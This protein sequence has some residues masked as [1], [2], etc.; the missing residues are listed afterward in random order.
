MTLLAVTYPDVERL[1]VTHLA[2][3]L[4][5]YLPAGATIGVGVPASWK[6]ASPIHVEVAWDGTPTM[7]HPIVANATV[8]IVVRAASTSTA[9]TYA[10]L[11]EGVLCAGDW[12]DTFSVQPLTGVLPAR[13]PD[14]HAELAS[15][16]V[17]VNVRSTPIP[18]I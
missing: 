11:T 14:T 8:R 4:P 15:F 5:A 16:T 10:A 6:P 2:A 12:P 1:V 18:E 9:K 3:V 17:R 13:D 7:T